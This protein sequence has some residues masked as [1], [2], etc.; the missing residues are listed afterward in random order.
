MAFCLVAIGACNP[1]TPNTTSSFAESPIN[2]SG[3]S[4]NL[5]NVTRQELFKKS[6]AEVADYLYFKVLD[7]T[8]S[9]NTSGE[10]EAKN[11]HK[12]P[13]HWRA[14]Y[15]VC[16]LQAEVENGGHDQFFW[17]NRGEFDAETESDLRFIGA[18]QFLQLYTKARDLYYNAPPNKTERLPELEPIDDAFYQQP[19]T[20]YHLMGEYILSHLED[21][22]AE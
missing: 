1:K 2:S 9:K 14:V 19:V 4:T 22:C 6:P 12:L 7:T 3:S 5:P 17:N 11:L 20:P 15:T 16:W 8:G 21:Y 18:T 10:E 13:Q